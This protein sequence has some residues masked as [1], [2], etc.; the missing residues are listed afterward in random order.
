MRKGRKTKKRP[1]LARNVG[2]WGNVT[3]GNLV[4]RYLVNLK[5]PDWLSSNLI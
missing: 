1:G 3:L 4:L 5:V 2:D